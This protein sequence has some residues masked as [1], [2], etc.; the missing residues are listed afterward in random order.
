V[1]RALARE[2]VARLGGPPPDRPERPPDRPRGHG[3]LSGPG[4]D[5][6]GR[7]SGRT[8]TWM[9]GAGAITRGTTIADALRAFGSRAPSI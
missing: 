2:A 5:D 6:I 7:R 3:L 9:G 8:I 4:A 1:H